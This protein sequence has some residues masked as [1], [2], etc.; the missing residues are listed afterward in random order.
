LIREGDLAWIPPDVK[1]WDGATAMS[2]M[3]RTAIVESR[4]GKTV[5][6]LEM[7]DDKEYNAVNTEKKP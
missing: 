4:G 2:R 5:E 6:W 1:H 3:T 7:V